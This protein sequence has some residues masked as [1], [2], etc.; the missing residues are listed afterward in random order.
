MLKVLEVTYGGEVGH[1]VLRSGL[2]VLTDKVILLHILV[3]FCK[4]DSVAVK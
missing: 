2:L 1:F 4:S 3:V